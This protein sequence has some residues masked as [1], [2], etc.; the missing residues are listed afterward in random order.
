MANSDEIAKAARWRL[1]RALT[2]LQN[3]TEAQLK[4]LQTAKD[5]IELAQLAAKRWRHY[6][7]SDSAAS[8][9][10]ELRT[11]IQSNQTGEY[12]F[13][14]TLTA[15]WFPG[16]IL[17]EVMLR[18]TWCHHLF[19]DFL[20]VHPSIAGQTSKVKKGIGYALLTTVAAS[21]KYLDIPLV[22]GEATEISSIWY[23][24]QLCQKDD[25]PVKDH[26][27]IRETLI[28]KLSSKF[29]ENHS[30]ALAAQVT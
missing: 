10:D 2:G 29:Q 11:L 3:P 18:R 9:T 22:W 6:K 7:D 17:G 4:L 26:F 8:S 5:G 15:D 25:E 23:S 14:L 13:F 20:Y 16:G 19:M 21:A 28:S 24:K 1:P 27:F 12:C 30:F